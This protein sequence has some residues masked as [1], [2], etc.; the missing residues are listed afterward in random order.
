M[1]KHLPAK[2]EQV[3]ALVEMKDNQLGKVLADAAIDRERERTDRHDR[4]NAFQKVINELAL[5]Y[6]EQIR[7]IQGE[8]KMDAEKDR[9][10]FMQR[11]ADIGTTM[12]MAIEKQTLELERAIRT[13][14]TFSAQTASPKIVERG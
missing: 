8:H 2:D 4:N 5:T 3:K 10:A 13:S 14:C 7:A 9:Q 12:K 1:L 11:S 6:A